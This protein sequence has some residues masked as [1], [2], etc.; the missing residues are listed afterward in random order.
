MDSASF[1]SLQI[2]TARAPKAANSLSPAHFSAVKPMPSWV[3]KSAPPAYLARAAFARSTIA[4]HTAVP[5][6]CPASISLPVLTNPT[7]ATQAVFFL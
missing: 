7:P 1:N 2:I 3:S 5:C 4:Q 6:L